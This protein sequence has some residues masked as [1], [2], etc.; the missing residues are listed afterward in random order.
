MGW[1]RGILGAAGIAGL[2][3][4]GPDIAKKG[5]DPH[6][7]YNTNPPHIETAAAPTPQQVTPGEGT[8]G[9]GTAPTKRIHGDKLANVQVCHGYVMNNTLTGEN[10]A[11][12]IVSDVIGQGAVPQVVEYLPDGVNIS[13]P[14]ELPENTIYTAADGTISDKPPSSDKCAQTELE[15]RQYYADNN[16]GMRT[17]LH[18]I[19]GSTSDSAVFSVLSYREDFAHLPVVI[20]RIN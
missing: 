4:F 16:G 5:W 3:I 2:L 14:Y 17:A 15:V 9:G 18:E 6:Y 12:F 20:N 10:V 19:G 11:N 8:P 13:N 1:H 7:Q